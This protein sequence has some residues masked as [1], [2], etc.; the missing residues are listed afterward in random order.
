MSWLDLDN[1]HAEELI[2]GLAYAEEILKLRLQPE[3]LEYQV[4]EEALAELTII[5]EEL[6]DH[7]PDMVADEFLPSIFRHPVDDSEPIIQVAPEETQTEEQANA[8]M[9]RAVGH[10]YNADPYAMPNIGPTEALAE[11]AIRP[12]QEA[13]ALLNSTFGQ[14]TEAA[15]DGLSTIAG[16]EVA[17]ARDRGHGNLDIQQ[18]MSFFDDDSKWKDQA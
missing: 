7:I 18:D 14:N 5:Q 6:R 9:E 8:A 12:S 13:V 15:L 2:Q 17:K 4:N 11:R 3:S 10:F 1:L 16:E